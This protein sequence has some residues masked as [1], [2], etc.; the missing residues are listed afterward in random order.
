MQL[1]EFVLVFIFP[2]LVLIV[3]EM[4]FTASKNEDALAGCSEETARSTEAL[5]WAIP[6]GSGG[7]TV[8]AVPVPP[9]TVLLINNKSE[10]LMFSCISRSTLTLCLCLFSHNIG[11]LCCY[12]TYAMVPYTPHFFQNN[13]Y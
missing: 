10:V 9:S 13:N 3:V 11:M 6:L 4:K 7:Y 1:I 2:G 5:A 12:D 8:H